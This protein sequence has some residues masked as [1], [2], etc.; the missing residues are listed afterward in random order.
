MMKSA[1]IGGMHSNCD[2]PSLLGTEAVQILYQPQI[3]IV[4]QR[5]GGIISVISDAQ[6]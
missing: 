6:C 2:S 5:R 3:A 1:S 4:R